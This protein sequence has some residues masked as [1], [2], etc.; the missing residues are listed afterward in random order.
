MVMDKMRIEFEVEDRPDLGSFEMEGGRSSTVVSKVRNLAGLD[1]GTVFERN[2]DEPVGAEIEGKRALSLIVHRC[3]RVHVRV[4]YEHQT[5]EN[6]FA[7]SATVFRVLRWA[8]SKRG[9]NL[10]DT[11]QAK[12]NL[13]LPGADQPLPKDAMIG[14]FVKHTDCG[15]VL[16]LTLK[17]FTN[18]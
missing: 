14:R 11:A 4:R 2:S 7:P 16:D 8:V 12:A 5:K 6:D 3:R 13:M 18:G 1:D 15:L 10:D 17:D 9:F